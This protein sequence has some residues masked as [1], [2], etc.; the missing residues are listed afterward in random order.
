MNKRSAP[1]AGQRLLQRLTLC[2]ALL[3]APPLLAQATPEPIGDHYRKTP[4]GPSIGAEHLDGI[5]RDLARPEAGSFELWERLRR[6]LEETF[7]AGESLD[8]PRW[9][10]DFRVSDDTVLFIFYGA[11][12]LVVLLSLAIIANELRLVRW[13][14]RQKTQGADAAADAPVATPVDPDRLPL[15]ELPAFLLKQILERLAE[16]PTFPRRR[17]A[18]LTHQE[19]ERAAATLA[20]ALAKPLISTA[21][22]AERIRYAAAA[23]ESTEIERAV[24]GS[25]AL[26]DT[27]EQNIRTRP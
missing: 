5:L 22:V 13:R 12:A 2:L 26:L 27:L 18:S 21:A 11:C 4:P 16:H 17:V 7:G 3:L 1:G 24:A 8:L 10:E 14:R 6:W 25:R 15:L 9:L 20:P 23:P 19:I